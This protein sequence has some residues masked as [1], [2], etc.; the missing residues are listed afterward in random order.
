MIV[1]HATPSTRRHLEASNGCVEGLYIIH[2]AR[3]SLPI[4]PG[5]HRPNW[6]VTRNTLAPSPHLLAFAF[7][8][9]GFRFQFQGLQLRCQDRAFKDLACV[10]SARPVPS[11]SKLSQ[12][13]SSLH[14]LPVEQNFLPLG[15]FQQRSLPHRWPAQSFRLLILGDSC[16]SYHPRLPAPRWEL[17][18]CWGQHNRRHW[19]ATPLH[20][21]C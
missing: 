19:T 15:E 16:S 2:R 12:R 1:I 17:L 8:D 7:R 5:N 9:S 20:R 6:S 14:S 13:G 11:A 21:P 3:S 18:G 10:S 4:P